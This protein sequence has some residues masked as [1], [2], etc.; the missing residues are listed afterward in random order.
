MNERN[1]SELALLLHSIYY[2]SSL[3]FLSYHIF[4]NSLLSIKPTWKY[5]DLTASLLLHLWSL[6]CHIKMC[7]ESICLLLSYYSIFCCRIL[8]SEIRKD[9]GERYFSPTRHSWWNKK[10]MRSPSHIQDFS[11]GQR[12]TSE[13]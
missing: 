11:E 6:S 4:Y 7:I 12:L 13:A 8:F 1:C 2:T 9:R 10:N 5:S 3:P